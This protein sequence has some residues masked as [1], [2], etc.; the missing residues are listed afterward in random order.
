MAL[1]A[2][3]VIRVCAMQNCVS[4]HFHALRDNL[5][6]HAIPSSAENIKNFSSNRRKNSQKNKDYC[7]STAIHCQSAEMI[8]L[9]TLTAWQ[10]SCSQ[11]ITLLLLGTTIRGSRNNRVTRSEHFGPF[12]GTCLQ[13]YLVNL[14]RVTKIEV[15]IL[16]SFISSEWPFLKLFGHLSSISSGHPAVYK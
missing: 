7:C 1:A 11:I 13:F 9:Q 16:N 10:K 4:R 15:D 2:A 5:L 12:L 8:V 14:V 3:A 6:A